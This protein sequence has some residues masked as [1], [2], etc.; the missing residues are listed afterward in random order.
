MHST[1]VAPA[2]LYTGA[3][4]IRLSCRTV[5]W[6]MTAIRCL[7]Q[8]SILFGTKSLTVWLS[9]DAKC[10]LHHAPHLLH[11]HQLLWHS[12]KTNICARTVKDTDQLKV[13]VLFTM[14]DLFSYHKARILRHVVYDGN[15]VWLIKLVYITEFPCIVPLKDN[16]TNE[17]GMQIQLCT[18]EQRIHS[19]MEAI[20]SFCT[21]PAL[22]QHL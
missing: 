20:S 2:F 3:S 7:I 18:G 9:Q 15:T 12:R 5:T 21:G 6:D 22:G 8:S 19:N 14:F 16:S 13:P 17:M 1:S 10:Q 4:K 11:P